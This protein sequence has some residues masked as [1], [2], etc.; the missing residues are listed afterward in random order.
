MTHWIDAT[1]MRGGTSKGLFFCERDLPP[2]G[3]ERDQVFTAA[4]GSPDPFGRQLDGMGGGSSSTSKVVAVTV[5]ERPGVALEYMFGQVA[6]GEAV[7][8]YSGNCGNLSSAV[9]PFALLTGLLAAPPDGLAS[10]RMLNTNTGKLIDVRLD[11]RDGVAA[12]TGDLV[13]PGVAGTGAAIELSYLHP[14]GSRTSGALPTGRPVDLLDVGDRQLAASLVD[15]ASPMVFVVAADVGLTGAEPPDD[16]DSR[17]DLLVLLD[18][19]RRAAAVA[20]GMCATPD[21]APLAFPK[22]AVVAPPVDTVL[23]DGTHAAADDCDVVVRTLSMGVTHR[24]VP[25]TA[26]LCAAAA[27]AI[28][29]TVL[30]RASAGTV[31]GLRIATPSGVVVAAADVRV[32]RDRVEVAGASL[33]RTARALM[34]GQVAVP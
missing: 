21:E 29:G 6:V 8:D 14:A 28:P 33:F 23:L 22:V 18:R 34:R 11:V 27:A 20:M 13:L 4:L 31:P 30:H 17:A 26:A 1:F 7:V 24:A 32:E 2:A 15:V 25:G 10:V 3:P 16:L 12:T 19:V 5:S 9:V